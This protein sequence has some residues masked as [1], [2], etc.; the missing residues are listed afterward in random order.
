MSKQ[1]RT[2]PLEFKHEAVT[3][4]LEP[5]WISIDLTTG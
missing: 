5:S 1:Q 2:F 4:V 3:L